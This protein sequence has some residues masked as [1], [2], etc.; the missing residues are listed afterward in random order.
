MEN[1][2][3]VAWLIR[4]VRKLRWIFGVQPSP[5]TVPS[6]SDFSEF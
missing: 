4:V 5:A 3:S 6:R 1:V 2:S